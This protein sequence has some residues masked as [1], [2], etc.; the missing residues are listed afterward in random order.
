MTATITIETLDKQGSFDAYVAEPAGEAKA[1]IVVI[2]EIFGVN[3]G[4]QRKC[5]QLAEAG[6]LAVAPDLFWR[7]EPGIELDPDI[8]DQFQAALGWMGKFNQDLG[9]RDIEATI[10]TARAKTDGGKVGAVGYCLGG[11]LAYMT[12]ARTDVDASVGYYAVGI[13]G[14]LGEKHAIARPLMLHIAGADH[15]VTPDIQAKMHEG[16]DDYPK[17]T[18][19]DYP[20]VDHGF[21]TEFGKRRVDEAARLADKR[22]MAFFAE[23]LA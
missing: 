7:L 2:Q 16:L 12:A 14:L 22:T 9:I 23:N 11:R 13:D 6:Y 20:G 15:F 4:I 8:P 3:A 17:V 18:L 5:D 1:A 10:R 19:H 21:A